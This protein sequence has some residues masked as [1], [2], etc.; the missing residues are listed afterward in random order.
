MKIIK[1][2]YYTDDH[3]WIKVD[4]DEAYI[5]ITDY[6]QNNLGNIVYIDLPQVD[7]EFTAG[8]SFGVVESDKDASDLYIPLDGKVLEVNEDILD[9]PQLVNKNPYKNW[10]I[11]VEMFDDSQV[12]ELMDAKEYKEYCKREL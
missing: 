6:A 2:L 9:E 10:M 5:G 3:E 12:D 4:G 11:K 8:D 7:T 1:K